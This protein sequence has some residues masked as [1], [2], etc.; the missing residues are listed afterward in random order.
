MYNETNE[1]GLNIQLNYVDN[2]S[3]DSLDDDF[4]TS[5]K[6]LT[7]NKITNRLG[8]INSNVNLAKK[9]TK[10]SSNIEEDMEIENINNIKENKNTNNLDINLQNQESNNHHKNNK[11][12]NVEDDLNLRIINSVINVASR[13]I[14]TFEENNVNYNYSNKKSELFEDKKIKIQEIFKYKNE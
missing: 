3:I 13:N 4:Q 7:F 14:D 6:F 5:G 1:N 10:M 8:E 2:N 11:N 9:N 12:D